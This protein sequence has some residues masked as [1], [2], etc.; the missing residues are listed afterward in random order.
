MTIGKK[1]KA[2]TEKLRKKVYERDNYECIS[3]AVYAPCSS[4]ITIQH[5]V[6]R[7][8]GGSALYDGHSAFLVAMCARHNTLETADS[9]YHKIC[10]H[11]GWSVPRW[12]VLQWELTQVPVF[13]WDGWHFLENDTRVPI[14]D[15]E[16]KA[17]RLEI[18]G[19]KGE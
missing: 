4:D 6:S 9:D 10:Q 16:A 3:K 19:Y 12:V 11:F 17:R 5:R 18:Y 8:M 2:Q 13:Y 1:S 14:T 7:G 15:E